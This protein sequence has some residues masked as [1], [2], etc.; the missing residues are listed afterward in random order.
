MASVLVIEDDQRIRETIVATAPD[1]DA[2]IVRV[3]DAGADDYVIKPR[4]DVAGP[5]EIDPDAPLDRGSSAGGS[6]GLG[7][8]IA[9][10]TTRAAGG[11]LHMER[12][13]LGGARLVLDLPLADVH[14]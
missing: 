5:P 14:R 7:R 13:P 1:D 4:A 2:E 6:T 12:P 3:P 8:A 11:N 9:R 10:S